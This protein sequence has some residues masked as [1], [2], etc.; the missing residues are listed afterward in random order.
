MQ[1]IALIF[2]L[3][4]NNNEKKCYRV[5]WRIQYSKSSY[6]HIVKKP[7]GSVFICLSLSVYRQ[8]NNFSVTTEDLHCTAANGLKAQK[9][10]TSKKG[11]GCFATHSACE[12][13]WIQR[14]NG[15]ITGI[16][17]WPLVEWPPSEDSVLNL[18]RLI[19]LCVAFFWTAVPQ[20]VARTVFGSSFL[21]VFHS[22]ICVLTSCNRP[23]LVIFCVWS[24]TQGKVGASRCSL[25]PLWQTVTRIIMSALF[26][27]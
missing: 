17:N 26:T 4:T 11:V 14:T 3:L 9:W 6:L 12:M 10:S 20:R 22:F 23:D 27:V 8:G 16:P 24:D 18:I 5:N 2:Y 7:C 25:S 15:Q 21:K 1:F 13:N 19:L